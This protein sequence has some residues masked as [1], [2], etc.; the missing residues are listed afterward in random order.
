[1][2][3]GER[4]DA[5]A[6]AARGWNVH[7]LWCG[8]TGCNEARRSLKKEGVHLS[9]L[10]EI[11]MPADCRAPNG[12]PG[13]GS[14]VYTSNWIRYAVEFL[15]R[16]HRFDAVIFP[17][18]QAAGFRCVQAKQAGTAFADANLVVRLDC[19]SQWRREA[20]K[21]WPEPDDLFID[22][23]ERYTF[24]NA[25]IHWILSA[26][27]RD[28]ARRLGWAPVSGPCREKPAASQ[29]REEIVFVGQAEAPGAL[30]LF[31]DASEML[32]SDAPIAFLNPPGSRRAARTIASRMKRRPY[33]VR[34]GLDQRRLLE[35]LAW[36][37]Q[38]AVVCGRSD[39]LPS[40]VRDC[41]VNGLPFVAAR[42][43]WLPGRVGDAVAPGPGFFDAEGPGAA[44]RLGDALHRE[45]H[46]VHEITGCSPEVLRRPSRF[47]A[48]APHRLPTSPAVTIAVSYYNLGRYLPETL[49]S[50]A[51]QTVS[52][53]EVLVIDDGSTCAESRRV[54]EEQR[55]R[56][57]HFRFIRQANAG[58][59]AARNRALHEATA[60]YFIPVDADNIAAPGMAASFLQA[61]QSNPGVSAMTCFF[62]AFRDI[63][64]IK[65]G[66]FLH[67][68]CPTGGPDLAACACNV[69]GDANAIFRTDDLHAVGGFP[70]DRSTYCHDWE[71][72]VKLARDGRRIGVVPEYLFYYRKRPD[73][74]SAAM[75][76]NGTDV[77][78]FVQRMLAT[79]F[80]GNETET[81]EMWAMLAGSLLR[82]ARTEPP[83]CSLRRLWRGALRR[84]VAAGRGI[85]RG[86]RWIAGLFHAPTPQ[87]IG[88]LTRDPLPHRHVHQ[89][90]VTAAGDDFHDGVAPQVLQRRL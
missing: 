37:D 47:R 82:P 57:P 33:T 85:V 72:F 74:M 21:R 22:Y 62:L 88:H 70:T 28:E 54:W 14:A 18:W 38:L 25:D 6:L 35:Y 64:D 39:T 65:K 8:P 87:R 36:G 10:G 67:Q 17:A 46:G 40:L 29:R 48:A 19:I 75:T 59:G 66:N 89:A 51:A 11:P 69:Y 56:Y 50:L 7:C 2:P 27:M 68:V 80:S 4:R 83:P 86:A 60:P 9:R 78:P 16:R 31:L 81:A 43:R 30:D 5:V 23:C 13:C 32:D 20:E 34:R 26:Y 1:L 73:A 63:P 24:N 41:I 44:E 42:P 12:T 90:G 61:M 49:A 45:L 58:L 84:S 79:F 71:T 55:R 77:Y 3:I 53:I 76:R 52:D 15:H